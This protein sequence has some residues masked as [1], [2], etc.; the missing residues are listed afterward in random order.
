M[1]PR[2]VVLIAAF[3]L[4]ATVAR[5]AALPSWSTASGP[6]LTGYTLAF[7]DDF[8]STAGIGDGRGAIPPT[9]PWWD[10]RHPVLLPG[11][12]YVGAGDRKAY[13]AQ[14]GVLTLSTYV[15]AQG[16]NTEADIE[17]VRSFGPNF[18]AEV[19]MRGPQV[20]GVHAGVW[21]LSVDN[22]R[23]DVTG[24]HAELDLVEQYGPGDQGDHSASHVWPGARKDVAAQF[25]SAWTVRPEGKAV[26]WHTY[27]LEATDAVFTIW[28]D[29]APVQRIARL[30]SQRV[31][32]YLL[33]SLF[34][35]QAHAPP[36]TLQVDYVRVWTAP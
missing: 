32:M 16:V 15:N 23:A 31:P 26:A 24:G 18:Y 35:A 6:D 27:G 20:N 22:G 13:S 21:F 2:L 30:P 5:P 19:R 11:E 34:G 1:K 33:L 9:T 3:A 29:G 36:A 25:T 4:P 10:F 28:R 17:T 14:G 7:S 12:T 8:D